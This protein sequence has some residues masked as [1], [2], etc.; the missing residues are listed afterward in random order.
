[1]SSCFILLSLKLTCLAIRSQVSKISMHYARPSSCMSNSG[2][3]Y[4][5]SNSYSR[6]Q[7]KTFDQPA[8]FDRISPSQNG[9][10]HILKSHFI[11][12]RIIFLNIS[13]LINASLRKKYLVKFRWAKN[14]FHFW[15]FDKGC[16]I[17]INHFFHL[18][19][20]KGR[21]LSKKYLSREI[22]MG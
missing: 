5:N 8:C 21:S 4:A 20:A 9:I 22:A 18:L 1:M 15:G 19:Y 16:G 14:N 17:F 2:L 12:L 10:K 13:V 6:H 7:S 11:F 3:L